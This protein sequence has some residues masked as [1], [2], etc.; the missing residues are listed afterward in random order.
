MAY[1]HMQGL[2]HALN[3]LWRDLARNSFPYQ[4]ISILIHMNR[5][6][7]LSSALETY[8]FQRTA[9]QAMDLY[10]KATVK[11]GFSLPKPDQ[12]MLDEAIRIAGYIPSQL[13]HYIESVWH[14]ASP[15]KPA[16]VEVDTRGT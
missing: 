7:L 10:D 5:Q 12:K 6:Q 14:D 16:Y 11:G 13:A 4:E 1:S 3:A 15:D 2:A 9:R 8:D